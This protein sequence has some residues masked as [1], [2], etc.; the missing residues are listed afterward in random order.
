M[1]DPAPE[2]QA[3]TSEQA[4]VDLPRQPADPWWR[5][6]IDRNPMFLISGV[7]MLV[8]CFLVSQHVH[9][10]DPAD[11]GASHILKLIVG[12]LVVLNVYEF[13]VIGLGLALA[14]SRTLVRDARHLLGLAILLLVDAGFVYTESGITS[15]GVGITIAILAALLALVKV[16]LVLRSLRIHA[17]GPAMIVSSLAL[18]AMYAMPII[19][20]SLAPDGF[21]PQRDAMAVWCGL[22]LVVGLYALPGRWLRL[23]VA[24]SSDQRQLQHLVAGGLIVLPIVSLIAHAVAALWVYKN[25]FEPAMLS[26]M[27]LGFAA[28]MLRHHRSLGGARPTAHAAALVVASA[29]VASLLPG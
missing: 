28:V 13:A 5:W 22:G 25:A 24:Q 19:V 2:S 23:G 26:P 11:A 17:S 3:P 7:L 6:I 8:G 27:L 1:H 12:L 4:T 29:V 18:S 15:P 9:A 10:L 14:K 16:G 21:L 20:R